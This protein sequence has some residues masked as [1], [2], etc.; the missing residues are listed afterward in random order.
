MNCKFCV[1]LHTSFISIQ[2]SQKL[3]T[4]LQ[5][6]SLLCAINEVG[7]DIRDVQARSLEGSDLAK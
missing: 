4:L 1:F 7:N 5:M 6:V 2:T 3:Q